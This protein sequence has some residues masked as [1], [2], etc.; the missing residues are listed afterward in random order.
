MEKEYCVSRH[1]AQAN[2]DTGLADPTS[3]HR[4]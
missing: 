4:W 2:L 3:L 1:R